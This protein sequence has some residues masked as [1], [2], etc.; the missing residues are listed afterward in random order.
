MELLRD[1]L[2]R[3]TG[4]MH[5]LDIKGECRRA[6][7]STAVYSVPTSAAAEADSSAFF[8]KFIR[9]L[10]KLSE[11]MDRLEESLQREGRWPRRRRRRGNLRCHRC[12]QPGHIARHCRAPAPIPA[13]RR[14]PS[15]A[16]NPAPEI[17]A[18]DSA[19]PTAAVERDERSNEVDR[20]SVLSLTD[21]SSNTAAVSQVS[22]K[23]RGQRRRARRKTASPRSPDEVP[24]PETGCVAVSCRSPTNIV[25]REEHVESRL[26]QAIVGGAQK[27]SAILDAPQY[28]SPSCVSDGGVRKVDVSPKIVRNPGWYIAPWRTIATEEQCV[29]TVDEAPLPR[30]RRR[31]SLGHQPPR[32]VTRPVGSGPGF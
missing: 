16:A 30:A 11:R 18:R 3:I 22:P 13:G 15:V 2:S 26:R 23:S 31:P 10:N 27:A 14:Q 8:T 6:T 12:Q 21:T 20:E 25:P 5:C 24:D 32:L 4:S 17:D 19:V 9:E 1:E 29:T 7:C 28:E